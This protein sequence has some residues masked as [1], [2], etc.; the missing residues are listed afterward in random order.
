M[1]T[2]KGSTAEGE[3]RLVGTAYLLLGIPFFGAVVTACPVFKF[4]SWSWNEPMDA[5]TE[6]T[7]GVFFVLSALGLGVALRA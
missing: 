2:H 6:W 1:K 7:L 3:V 4:L 5:P